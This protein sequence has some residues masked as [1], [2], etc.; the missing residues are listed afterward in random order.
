[1]LTVVTSLW[2]DKYTGEHVNR[3][4]NQLDRHL[5]MPFEF[6]ALVESREGIRCD[7]RCMQIWPE[8][9]KQL[10][11]KRPNCYRRLRL[12]SS[13]MVDLFGP[14]YL[15]NL[16]LDILI[17]DEITDLIEPLAA[18]GSDITFKAYR[19]RATNTPYNGGMWLLK[20]GAHSE[21]W[22]SFDKHRSPRITQ[23]EGRVGSDQAWIAHALGPDFPTWDERHGVYAFGRD[24]LRGNGGEL[25]EDAKMVM[26]FG[27]YDPAKK[28]LRWVK[29]HWQ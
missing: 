25:P 22:D 2:G 21:V 13:E 17:T 23:E 8:I 1:M 19:D 5:K 28:Q 9:S 29:E 10:H 20:T 3:L 14:G 4:K 12:F 7:I 18:G 6:I 16:D 27:P 11:P 24:I 26:M 15:L